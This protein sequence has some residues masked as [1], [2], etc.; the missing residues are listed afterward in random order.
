MAKQYGFYVEVDKCVQCHACEVACKAANGVDLGVKW[1]RVVTVWNGTYP[2]V[3]NESI[4][5]SCMHCGNPACEA[6]CPAGAIS[7]D[8][9][10]GV[11]TVDRS[12]C[13]GCHYCFFACPVGVPQY[14]QDGTMQ[15]CHLCIEKVSQGQDPPCVWTCPAG[16]LHAGPL[17][18][19][20]V[21]AQEQAAKRLTAA[22]QPSILFSK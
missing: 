10:T 17:E 22:T 14:G 7:K 19:L 13:I 12:K 5:L 8:P 3:G 6:V 11:V 20:A 9:E 18:E 21:L 2:K 16:A 15:K 4:S 1:R